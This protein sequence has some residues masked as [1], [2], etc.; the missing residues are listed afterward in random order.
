VRVVCS[1]QGLPISEL[2]GM[3]EWGKSHSLGRSHIFTGI[4]RGCEG[5]VEWGLRDS[6]SSA[7]E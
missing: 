6:S 4:H 7:G 1:R 3:V 5:M 2:T